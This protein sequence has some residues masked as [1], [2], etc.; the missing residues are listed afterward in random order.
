MR[1]L[2]DFSLLQEYNEKVQPRGDKLLAL[3][4][5][6]AG[7]RFCFSVTT[8]IKIKVNEAADPILVLL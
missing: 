4:K 2:L 3:A 8:Y 6:V 1:T 7:M 5:L